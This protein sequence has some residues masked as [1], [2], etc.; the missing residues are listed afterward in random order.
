MADLA[1]TESRKGRQNKCK[2][3]PP[4]PRE[5]T[6]TWRYPRNCRVVPSPSED[7]AA[8]SRTRR[9]AREMRKLR[10]LHTLHMPPRSP[11]LGDTDAWCFLSLLYPICCFCRELT[12]FD[13]HF[14]FLRSYSDN[15]LYFS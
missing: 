15:T 1:D 3:P 9:M 8:N 13:P 10:S 11:R 14:T 2:T 5:N 4:S 12:I 7:I 6:P